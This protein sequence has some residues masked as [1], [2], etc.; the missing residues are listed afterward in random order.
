MINRQPEIG[1]IVSPMQQSMEDFKEQ[2]GRMNDQLRELMTGL[3]R[4]VLQIPNNNVTTG[5]SLSSNSNHP[6]SRLS[7]IEFPR[8]NVED[9][10]GW[11]YRSE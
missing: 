4:Q 9:V 2:Q 7:R 3:G 11:I 5:E 6:L 10:H 8:F 1:G